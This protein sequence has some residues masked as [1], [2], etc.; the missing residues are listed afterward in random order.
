[1]RNLLGVHWDCAA[2]SISTPAKTR[3]AFLQV[4]FCQRRYIFLCD[5]NS[6][7]MFDWLYL[8][9]L[10]VMLGDVSVM[11]TTFSKF[12]LKPHLRKTQKD[13]CILKSFFLFLLNMCFIVTSKAVIYFVKLHITYFTII[14]NFKSMLCHDYSLYAVE[15]TPVFQIRV[16]Y[17]VVK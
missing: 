8:C 4:L 1:M 3:Q 17:K 14:D 16:T 5:T 10:D 15:C 11:P 13:N 9:T 2:C 7:A 6:C 12:L